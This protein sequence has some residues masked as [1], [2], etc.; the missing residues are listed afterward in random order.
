MCAI[1]GTQVRYQHEPPNLKCLKRYKVK[2]THIPRYKVFASCP[3]LSFYV[4]WVHGRMAFRTL[5]TY[6]R[7]S[8]GQNV[9][10]FPL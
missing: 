7:T 8:H 2:T 1:I 10:V 3:Y 6:K 5:R 4:F 9:Y